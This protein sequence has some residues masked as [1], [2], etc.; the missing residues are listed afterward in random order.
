MSIGASGHH[1]GPYFTVDVHLHT[2][3][4]SADSN[5]SPRDLVERAR[6][7]GIGAVCITEHDTMGSFPR[8]ATRRARRACW[9]CAG[10]K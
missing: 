9:C 4:G 2:N 3:R 7:I 1:R 8:S 6:A 10:W 5:L